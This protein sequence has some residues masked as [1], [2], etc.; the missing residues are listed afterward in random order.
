MKQTTEAARL[1]ALV[2]LLNEREEAKVT[3]RPE[4][5][6]F[7]MHTLE[8]ITGS[9]GEP[10][11]VN[12][13][14]KAP[15]SP[16][17]YSMESARIQAREEGKGDRSAKRMAKARARA[18]R[19]MEF[20]KIA[21]SPYKPDQARLDQAWLV[22][23]HMVGIVSKIAKSKQRWANRLLGTNA[24]DIP[25]MALEAMALVLAKSDKDLSLLRRAAEELGAQSKK[26][27]KVPGDQLS[28]DERR[29]RKELGQARKWLMGM[30][31][32]R[33]MGALVDSYTAT[34]NLRWDNLDVIA[35]VI[36]SI[37]GPGEDPMLSNFK[38]SRAPA[39][40]GTRFQRPG[41]IDADLLAMGIT[42]A[43]TERGLDPLVEFILNDDHRRV[44]GAVKWSE[45][46]ETIFKLTPNGQGEQMWELVRMA[47][48][49]HAHKRKAR[50]DAA[51]QHV[52]NLF[53]F[54][55]GLIVALVDSFDPH[56]IAWSTG[57]HSVLASEF[58]LFYLPNKVQ[59]PDG[60]E[61]RLIL[62]PALRYGTVEEAA[63]VLTE[64][65]ALLTTG[66]DL[67]K[68]AVN[69]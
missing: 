21:N 26:S 38:A 50:G 25:Q 1:H 33:V 47:T 60:T 6:P 44:D 63:Q 36:A 59:H 19:K 11:A 43:I 65:L 32:N 57:G 27:G 53:E 61:R 35:T 4:D 8:Q 46:A 18:K 16:A 2:A 13:A 55:P 54:L 64:H 17:A 67:V 45:Y 3:K 34:H 40:L 49:H 24:D 37:N 15:D 10:P 62:E 51:R 68:S 14:A 29:E 7:A 20:D 56:F 41:G 66:S 28:D 22:V 31:N 12:M 58:E 48:Q 39:F 69:A 23:F 42:A 5:N 52:R 9:T 30:A